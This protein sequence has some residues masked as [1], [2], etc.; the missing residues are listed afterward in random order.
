MTSENEKTEEI[1]DRIREHLKKIYKEELFIEEFR[2]LPSGYMHRMDFLLVNLHPSRSSFIEAFEV[3]ASR[4][5]WLSELKR[6]SKSDGIAKYCDRMWLATAEGVASLEEI[7]RNWGWKMLKGQRLVTMKDAPILEPVWSREFII[8]LA[9]EVKTE[10]NRSLR[11]A[12]SEAYKEAKIEIE[13]KLDAD[14]FKNEAERYKERFEGLKKSVEIF[15][16]NTDINII[17]QR[18][19]RLKL[20]AQLVKHVMD[21]TEA[22]NLKTSWQWTYNLGRIDELVKAIRGDISELKKIKVFEGVKEV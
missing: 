6:P 17:H 11:D 14:Y 3:K 19:D 1:T 5:D 18:D 12:K 4:N 15:E 9:Q 22:K 2:D 21:L 7:P 8:T 16:Q 13:K 10:F 20:T